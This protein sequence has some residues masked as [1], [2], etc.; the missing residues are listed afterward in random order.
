ME[1]APF[2]PTDSAHAP[3]K[4]ELGLPTATALV[5]GNMIGSGIFLLPASLAAVALVSGSG[6]LLAWALTG[7]GA[8]L[9]AAVFATLGRAYPRTGGPYVF[10]HRAFGNFIGFQTAWGY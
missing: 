4:R 10:A 6:S 1:T 8:M 9:L 5:V 7:L 2:T 3:L